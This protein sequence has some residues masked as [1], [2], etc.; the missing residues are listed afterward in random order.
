MPDLRAPA[1][2][3]DSA[4][5]RQD[6]VQRMALDRACERAEHWPVELW[7]GKA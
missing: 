1:A 5:R 4:G 6:P 7:K 3:F 2:A